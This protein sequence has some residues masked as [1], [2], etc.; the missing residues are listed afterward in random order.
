VQTDG[1]AA[2]SDRWPTSIPRLQLVCL[3]VSCQSSGE[4]LG[5]MGEHPHK[6]LFAPFSISIDDQ[7]YWE[8]VLHLIVTDVHKRQ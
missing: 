8:T 1:S 2:L 4:D 6:I 3:S 7:L 5:T